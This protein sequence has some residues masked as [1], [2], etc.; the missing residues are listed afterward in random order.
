[1][2]IFTDAQANSV[3]GRFNSTHCIAPRKLLGQGWAM[4]E[5][6]LTDPDYAQFWPILSTLPTSPISDTSASWNTLVD[7]YSPDWPIGQLITI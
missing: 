5:Q 7:F 3:R 2:I 4:P 6:I 1:M